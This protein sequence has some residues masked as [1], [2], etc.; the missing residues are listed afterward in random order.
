[1]IESERRIAA[2]KKYNYSGY[3]RCRK[4]KKLQYIKKGQIQDIDIYYVCKKCIRKLNKI[5]I[6]TKKTI[7]LLKVNPIIISDRIIESSPNLPKQTIKEKPKEILFIVKIVKKELTSDSYLFY[8]LTQISCLKKHKTFK[9]YKKLKKHKRVKPKVKK[10][11]LN[12]IIKQ[13]R[14]NLIF[15]R[16][17]TCEKCH[18]HISISKYLHMHHI[19]RNRKN[20]SGT[21]LI[22]LCVMCHSKQH[23]DNPWVQKIM[24]KTLD[25][26]PIS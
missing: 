15:T 23:L 9:A 4:C 11:N 16:G 14:H 22:L 18:K 8:V 17:C 19:D 21:N 3:F 10:D 13:I 7:K 1:M 6:S 12:Y 24:K 26:A 5:V 2:A 25:S 20:N